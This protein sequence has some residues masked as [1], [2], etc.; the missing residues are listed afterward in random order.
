M[1]AVGQILP[2]TIPELTKKFVLLVLEFS[3]RTRPRDP[4]LRAPQI[5]SVS[6]SQPTKHR[7][8]YLS[9]KLLSCPGLNTYLRVPM[10]HARNLGSG[11]YV[12]Y[13]NKFFESG[14]GFWISGYKFFEFSGTEPERMIKI[15]AP[16]AFSF[17]SHISPD[18]WENLEPLYTIRAL[19]FPD[20]TILM[21]TDS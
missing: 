14:S 11:H 16:N 8:V 3:G 9:F 4:A 20:V 10:Y 17:T 5:R 18:P 15:N 19:Y 6:A 12:R 2:L 13:R 7:W 1:T 21:V